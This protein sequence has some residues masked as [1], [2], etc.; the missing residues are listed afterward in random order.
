MFSGQIADTG[1]S[2]EISAN[3]KHE[4]QI[5]EA[6]LLAAAENKENSRQLLNYLL[7]RHP[8]IQITESILTA[9]VGHSLQDMGVIKSL[10]ARSPDIK[11]T[12]HFNYVAKNEYP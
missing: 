10:L 5:T 3:Q 7:D 11:V 2:N 6:I 1:N 8:A 4:V 9:A 12:I